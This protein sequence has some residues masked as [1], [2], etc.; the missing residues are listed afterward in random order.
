M[1]VSAALL[2][3][4]IPLLAV[5][6]W[7]DVATR[8]IP[9]AASLLLALTGLASNL[10]LQPHGVVFSLMA[11]TAL[12]AVLLFLFARGAL[13]GGDVKLMAAL[14]LGMTAPE[15]WHFVVVTAM[16]G[17]V[18]ALLYLLLSWLLPAQPARP[19][20]P[21]LLRRVAHVEAWRIRR[22]GP[23]PYG[24]AIALG[25]AMILLQRA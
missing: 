20:A 4:S 12:F 18:L 22:R 15:I 7:R 5:V 23:L 3:A 1:D 25:A 9:D 17:G 19:A 11:A 21:G 14:A 8:T 10:V 24:I 6:A 13:G 16:A 2:S